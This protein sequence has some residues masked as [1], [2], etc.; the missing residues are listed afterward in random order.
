LVRVPVS[1]QY[2]RAYVRRNKTDAADCAALLEAIRASDIK[3]VPIKTQINKQF[4]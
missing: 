1:P 2:V 3:I 4:N